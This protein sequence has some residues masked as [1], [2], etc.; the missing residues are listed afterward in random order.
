MVA[1]NVIGL[2]GGPVIVGWLSDLLRPGYGENSLGIA[3]RC[4]LLAGVPSTILAYLASRTYKADAEAAR[5]K[6]GG[7]PDSPV[8]H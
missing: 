6:L 1:I 4:S 7:R 8:M 2:G 5:A 3:M